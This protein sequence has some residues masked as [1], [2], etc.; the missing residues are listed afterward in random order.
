MSTYTTMDGKQT[1]ANDPNRFI[2]YGVNCVYWTDDTSKLARRGMTPCCPKCGSVGFQSTARSFL[3]PV[4]IAEHE[5]NGHPNYAAALK[6]TKER[7][8]RTIGDA[9]EAMKQENPTP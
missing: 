4:K 6:W 3:D 5:A 1:T 2:W 8:Y 9:T 7:C